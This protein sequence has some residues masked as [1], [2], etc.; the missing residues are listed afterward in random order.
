MRQLWVSTPPHG[1]V[2]QSRH[3]TWKDIW[4][5]FWSRHSTCLHQRH[6]ACY[7]SLLDRTSY[8]PQ[9]Y[10]H[11]PP[12]GWAQGQHQKIM[13]WRPQFWL[14]VVSH[15]LWQGYAHTIESL[16]HLS[17]RSSKNCK[18]LRHFIGMINFYH[19]MWQKRF[20]LLAPLTSSTSKNVKYEWKYNHQKCFDVIKCVIWREVLLAYSDFNAPFEIHTDVSKLKVVEVIS[21]KGK[22]IAFYSRKMNNNKYNYITTEKELLYI[23]PSLKEFRNILL[24]HQ[25]TVYSD[26]KKSNL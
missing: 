22:P 24:G 23:V 20:E 13:L 2:Q 21:Q 7:R 8:F 10:V 4:T 17:P 14:F 12:E 9:R 18:K 15:H 19:D 1:S 16:G 5:L 3:L 25:I 11:P 26:H 6:S